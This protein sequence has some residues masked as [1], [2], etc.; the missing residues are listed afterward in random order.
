MSDVQVSDVVAPA[1]TSVAIDCTRGP[2]AGGV[3]VV[4]PEV[5]AVQ[6]VPGALAAMNQEGQSCTVAWLGLAVVVRDDPRP[7]PTCPT[8]TMEVGIVFA[9]VVPVGVNE[10]LFV[11]LMVKPPV[12]AGDVPVPVPTGTVIRTGDHVP[13]APVVVVAAVVTDL[14][15]KAAQV[16][17]EPVTTPQL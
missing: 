5:G 16:A 14:G 11:R 3:F 8:M 17:V 9:V 10:R 4:T 13:T 1:V 2:W 15:F 7:P 12:V 6:A